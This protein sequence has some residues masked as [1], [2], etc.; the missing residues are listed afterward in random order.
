MVPRS[1]KL[2]TGSNMGQFSVEISALPGSILNGNQQLNGAEDWRRHILDAAKRS[3]LFV[4]LS[5][6]V[7]LSKGGMIDE[8]LEV[9]KAKLLVDDDFLFL[10]IRID[11][12]R[13]RDWMLTRQYR[14]WQDDDLFSR[15]TV[16]VNGMLDPEA[17]SVRQLS[18]NVFL[19]TRPRTVEYETAACSYSYEIPSV[20]IVGDRHVA[21]E[22]NGVIRGQVAEAVLRMRGYTEGEPLREGAMQSMIVVGLIDADICDDNLGLSFEHFTSFSGAAHPNHDFIAVNV[23]RSPWGL[24]E[25]NVRP[26]D[27]QELAGL[28]ADAVQAE[29]HEF[30]WDRDMLISS[31]VEFEYDRYTVFFDGGVKLLFGDLAIGPYVNGPSILETKNPRVQ[32]ILTGN[33]PAAICV[34]E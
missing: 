19:N 9:A 30:L 17:E 33:P 32:Q 5:S 1:P 8:E 4:F 26:D 14:S 7:S 29:G 24:V 6:A 2:G 11:D 22:V 23:R 3:R 10:T 28:I 31:L 20:A 13:L 16:V 21:D 27:L 25:A 18:K 12:T 15:L 34:D